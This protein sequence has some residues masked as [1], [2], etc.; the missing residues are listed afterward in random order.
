MIFFSSKIIKTIYNSNEFHDARCSLTKLNNIRYSFIPIETAAQPYNQCGWIAAV[1]ICSIPSKRSAWQYLAVIFYSVFTFATSSSRVAF[2]CGS[3]CRQ[4][5]RRRLSK[6]DETHRKSFKRSKSTFNLDF[7]V[8][9]SSRRWTTKQ[10]VS[11]NRNFEPNKYS[12]VVH[13]SLCGLFTLVVFVSDS[14]PFSF[15]FFSRH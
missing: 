3:V 4:W 15:N 7:L 12:F 1:R 9:S 10:R 6:F 11:G 5:R 2:L 13:A 14:S 8:C